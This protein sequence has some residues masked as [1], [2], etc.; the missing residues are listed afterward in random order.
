M[1]V[2][3]DPK[4]AEQINCVNGSKAHDT[5]VRPQRTREQWIAPCRWWLE[6]LFKRGLLVELRAVGVDVVVSPDGRETS[7]TESGIFDS[8]H[9]EDMI[10]A[11]LSYENRARAVYFLLNPIDPDHPDI[12]RR[13]KNVMAK[14]GAGGGVSRGHILCRGLLLIDADTIRA[15]KAS[16]ATDEEKAKTY[17]VI[18]LVRAYLRACGFP[19]PVLADSG[20]GYHLLYR[21][22]L[23]AETDLVKKIL[24]VLA[25]RFD[26]DSVSID[27]VVHDAARICKFYGSFARK[28]Q[29]TPERPHRRAQILEVPGAACPDRRQGAKFETVPTHL[30]EALASEADSL[31]PKQ[32]RSGASRATPSPQPIFHASGTAFDGRLDV[33]RWLQ[34]RGVQFRT[35]KTTTDDGRTVFLLAKCPFN[36]AHGRAGEVS[37]MQSPDGKLSA[38]CMHNSCAGLGWKHFKLAIGKPDQEHYNFP[39]TVRRIAKWILGPN[40]E[41]DLWMESRLVDK[42]GAGAN[43]TLS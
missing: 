17:E 1:D 28:G 15:V 23:P 20:N 43:S 38:L 9:L 12:R 10:R 32:E 31:Q 4:S 36:A 13:R 34:S 42:P 30:L 7:H 39:P 19:D 18:L 11:A 16:S 5:P 40:G 27:T 25:D 21:I 6:L 24:A 22:D 41:D 8:A 33:P 35:K 37:I 3:P 29:D 2:L 26:T 14:V